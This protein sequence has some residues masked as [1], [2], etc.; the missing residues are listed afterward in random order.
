[1]KQ[2]NYLSP[3]TLPPLDNDVDGNGKTSDNLIV[4]MRPISQNNYPKPPLPESGML[5]FKQWLQTESWT[6]LYQLIT[7]HEKAEYLHNQLLSKLDSYLPEKV[8]KIR[9]DDKAWVNNYIK[10]LDKKCKREY[11]KRK[12]S[13][14][15]KLLNDEFNLTC[16]KA[17]KEYSRNIV[18]D[19]KTSNPSQWHSKIKRL[20]S[21]DKD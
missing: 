19:L 3:T 14:K 15:W 8:L 11:S 12:K 17:K 18:N 7:A 21:Q 16:E 4:I 2:G 6:E 10:L 9:K 20:S 1:M 13:M 5:M